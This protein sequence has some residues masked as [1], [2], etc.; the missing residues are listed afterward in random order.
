MLTAGI[1]FIAG[2]VLTACAYHLPQLVIGRVVLGFGVGEPFLNNLKISGQTFARQLWC[3]SD[4]SHR[5]VVLHCHDSCIYREMLAQI[6][7]A[8]LLSCDDRHHLWPEGVFL[9]CRPC[10]TG[11]ASVPE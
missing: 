2:A 10:H 3:C 4:L 11:S 5:R 7:S 8:K 9:L 1:C 6:I